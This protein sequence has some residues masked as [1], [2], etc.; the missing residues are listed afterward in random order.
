MSK[1]K[2]PLAIITPVSHR[3]YNSDLKAD[4]KQCLASVLPEG[5]APELLEL[6]Y[7][8][9]NEKNRE[10]YNFL[11]ANTQANTEPLKIKIITEPEH[12]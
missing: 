3:S 11:Q 6:Y 1:K 12:A 2:T 8:A 9:F 4:F 10:L 7:K 5:T